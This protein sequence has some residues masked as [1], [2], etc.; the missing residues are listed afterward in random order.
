MKILLLGDASNYHQSLSMG[1]ANMGHEVTVASHGS[2]W[3]NT[4][5]TIDISRR[6]GKLGGLILW[7]KISQ[8]LKHDLRG[9]D[10]VQ[11]HNPIFLSLRPHRVK[12]VFDELKLHNGKVFLTALGTDSAYISMCQRDWENADKAKLKYNEWMAGGQPTPNF[13]LKSDIY[14]A[15]LTDPLA[16]HCRYI[17]DNVDGVV[18]ALYE[19]H[20]AFEGLMPSE[21]LAYGGI[22]V[23]MPAA[24]SP[25]LSTDGKMKIM[26]ACHKGRE[27]EKGVDRMLP[28]IKAFADAN[29]DKVQLDFVQNV[30]FSQFQTILDNADIVVDQLYSYSPSTTPLMAM[31]RGKVA[32]TGGEEQFYDF[33]GEKTLRPIINPDPLN[34]DALAHDLQRI[35]ENPDKLRQ[36]SAESREFV[37]KHNSLDV[38]SRQFVEFWERRMR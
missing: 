6:A 2:S 21:K 17:Y 18:S 33:I 10:V 23:E 26:V 14:N 38:V 30:P 25:A 22:A 3:M 11:I 15:W 5:R 19:Y 24:V 12:A 28:V 9:Y 36:M 16:S 37:A 8:L 34:I 32:V 13:S 31:A 20:L 1:L 27:A 29:A 4:A 35:V 7:L